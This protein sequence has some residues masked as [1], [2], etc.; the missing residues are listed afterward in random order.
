MTNRQKELAYVAKIVETL[1]A[2]GACDAKI[3][4]GD[5][6]KEIG[7]VP[8]DYR[9]NIGATVNWLRPLLRAVAA[10]EKVN[11]RDFKVL[12]QPLIN[13]Q[14]GEIGEGQWGE[15]WWAANDKAA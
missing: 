10:F 7:L 6:A 14:T 11:G 1:E 5:L 2:Y 3:T 15:G 4:Y 9:W 12:F 8:R 13:K